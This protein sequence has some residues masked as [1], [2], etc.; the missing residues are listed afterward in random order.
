M[1]WDNVTPSGVTY[2][3]CQPAATP[4]RAKRTF[5]AG[6]GQQFAGLRLKR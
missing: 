6:I 1:W 5:K 4:L 2:Q 3:G